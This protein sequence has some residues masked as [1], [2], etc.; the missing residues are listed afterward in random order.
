M[1]VISG[2]RKE[3]MFFLRG[4]RFAIVLVVMIA[5]AVMSPLLF[6]AMS[7]MMTAMKDAMPDGTYSELADEFTSF[8]AA[9]ISMYNVEYIVSYGSI[10]MLFILKGAAG[11]EQKKRSVIIPQCSGLTPERFA[12]PKY[13]LYP[14]TVFLVSFLAVLLGSWTAG[15]MF[16]GSLDWSMIAL[17][18]ACSGV[19]LAFSTCMQLCVGISTGKPNIA[20]IIV[21]A[22]QMFLPTLLGIFRVDRFNPL[23]LSSIAL[24]AARASGESTSSLMAAIEQTSSSTND[25][26][27]LNIVVSLGTAI[28]ISTLLYFVTIFALHTKEV[29]NE[30]NEPVL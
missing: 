2:L 9:D 11:G 27:F 5:L 13:L 21:L 28:V 23:S 25:L 4:G 14:F 12:L 30:G 17:S 16:P 6:G 22:M 26:S 3:M 10:I 29:H 19:F 18:A 20:I 24:S 7:S 15:I 8:S 1:E